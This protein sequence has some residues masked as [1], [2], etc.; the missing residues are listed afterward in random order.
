MTPPATRLGRHGTVGA[1]VVVIA[2][3]VAQRP[4]EGCLIVQ[5]SAGS[6]NLSELDAIPDFA[7]DCL[8]AN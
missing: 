1:R 7:Q 3:G 5:A 4:G 8:A 2:G 6:H